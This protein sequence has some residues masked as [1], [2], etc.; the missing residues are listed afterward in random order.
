MPS[1]NAPFSASGP[2]WTDRLSSCARGRRAMQL[3]AAAVFLVLCAF[4]LR[5]YLQERQRQV[6]SAEQEEQLQLFI[7]TIA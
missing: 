6:V 5:H 4:G 2:S 3:L 7:R 1:C